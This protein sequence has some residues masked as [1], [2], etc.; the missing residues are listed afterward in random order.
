[1]IFPRVSLE[2]PPETPLVVPLKIPPE[3]HKKISLG[4]FWKKLRKNL[5]QSIRK[6]T[7]RSLEAIALRFSEKIP[8]EIN[9]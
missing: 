5:L 1:M 2:A 9:S 6:I 8:K 3:I 4:N 7:E